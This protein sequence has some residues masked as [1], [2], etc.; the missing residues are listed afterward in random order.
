[1]TSSRQGRASGT[2]RKR[3]KQNT[4]GTVPKL[5]AAA[6]VEFDHI[7][8]QS[9]DTA[10]FKRS[11]ISHGPSRK[12]P[13]LSTTSS[14]HFAFGNPPVRIPGPLGSVSTSTGPRQIFSW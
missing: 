5:G 11:K 13:Q 8:V 7:P 6:A 9:G 1:M 14:P 12:E 3:T 4:Q 2:E 10:S